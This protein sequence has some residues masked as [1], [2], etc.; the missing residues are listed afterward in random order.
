[1]SV[2]QASA[3][4]Q[5]TLKSGQGVMKY[6]EVEGPFTFAS[7][8]ET[9][10]GTNPEELIGAAHAGCYS[11]FLSALLSEQG[12]NPTIKTQA[13]VHLGE[14]D[15]PKITHIELDSQVSAEGLEEALLQE[16]GATAKEKCPISRLV[17]GAKISLNL[18]LV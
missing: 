9:G 13:K 1:M 10:P 3:V 8:F 4:W 5:G 12:F 2:Q 15:G 14:E 16:L 6:G 17:V 11:M 18:V 7:R